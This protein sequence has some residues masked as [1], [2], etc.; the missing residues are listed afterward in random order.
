MIR[1]IILALLL[2][3]CASL[4]QRANTAAVGD[5]VTTLGA[6]ALGAVEA[7]P[8]G[9]VTIP[10]KWAILG[11]VKTLPA[12]EQAQYHASAGA[13][14]GGA[15]VNN[16]CVIA[17]ILTA[18]TFAPVCIAAGIGYGIWAWREATPE[19]D[20]YAACAEA[21]RAWGMTEKCEFGS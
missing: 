20:F 2:S 7:N 9:L 14:W 8:L 13:I 11:Y 3:G 18:G 4:E 16:V 12:D 21:K 15:A 5:G 10:A 6:L 17:A 19:R 1:A